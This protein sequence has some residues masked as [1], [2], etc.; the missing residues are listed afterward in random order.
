MVI[1]ILCPMERIMNRVAKTKMQTSTVGRC[2]AG[3]DVQGFTLLELIIVMVL[4]SLTASFAVP[5]IRSSFY[6]DELSA[7][8]QSFVSLVTETAQKARAENTPFILR[9]QPDTKTFVALPVTTIPKTREEE[10]DKEYLRITLDDSISFT[11][12]EEQEDEDDQEMNEIRF[13]S[14]GYTKKA[15]VYFENESGDQCSV[16]L[17]PFLGVARILDDHVSLADDQITVRI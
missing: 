13:T 2:N 14:R 5:K 11:G 12:G 10:Q 3:S 1:L 16:I 15:V 4:I 17:S 8:A 7:A 9:F 6:R